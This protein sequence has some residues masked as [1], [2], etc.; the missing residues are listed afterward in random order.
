MSVPDPLS[1]KM[2]RCSLTL[3][4]RFESGR[5]VIKFEEPKPGT[6]N[7]WF[8]NVQRPT[9]SPDTGSRRP[10][11]SPLDCCSDCFMPSGLM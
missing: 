1:S 9:K 7:N 5:L 11:S 6:F 4:A 3:K 10:P 2:G 8:N